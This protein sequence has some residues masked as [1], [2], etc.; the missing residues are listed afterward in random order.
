M[1]DMLAGWEQ[2]VRKC[3]ESGETYSD[4]TR[5][6]YEREADAIHDLYQEVG[7]LWENALDLD[8]LTF[9][10]D[11]ENILDGTEPRAASR[12]QSEDP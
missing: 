2:Y 7:R 3:A 10:A 9:L 12:G 11:V 8:A 5:E 1:L 4:V 6:Q